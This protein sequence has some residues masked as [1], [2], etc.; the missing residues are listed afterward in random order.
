MRASVRWLAVG[1]LVIVSCRKAERAPA[2][3]RSYPDGEAGLKSLATDLP[4]AP[5]LGDSLVLP[6]P[7]AFFSAHFP[8]EVAARLADEYK[9][10]PPGLAAFLATQKKQGRTELRVEKFE[11]ADDPDAV[12]YQEHALAAM[13]APIPLYSLRLRA[14]GQRNGRHL[15]SFVHDGGQWRYLG[16]MKQVKAGLAEDPKLDAVA[17]LRAKDRETFFN[18]GRVPE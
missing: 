4:G 16:P 14:P 7:L 18:T 5:E 2:P 10:Q 11:R 8:L 15:Y 13:T 3:P 6:D 1:L 12:G 9:A 17:G